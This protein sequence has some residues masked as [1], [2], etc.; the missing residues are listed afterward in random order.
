MTGMSNIYEC[1]L[2]QSERVSVEAGDVIGIEIA[3]NGDYRFR[4]YFTVGGGPTNYQ[5]SGQVSTA[6]L[7]QATKPIQDQPQISLTVE[8]IMSTTAPVLLIS[9]PPPIATI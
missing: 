3:E 5:F 8:P 2:P 9:Q 7:S 4:L 6:T 1:T